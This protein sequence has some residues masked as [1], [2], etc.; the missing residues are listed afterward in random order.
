MALA[1]GSQAFRD[2]FGSCLADRVPRTVKSGRIRDLCLV[3]L[4]Q[5][6]VRMIQEVAHADGAQGRPRWNNHGRR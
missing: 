5:D 2:D 3:A 4:D 1:L 6:D